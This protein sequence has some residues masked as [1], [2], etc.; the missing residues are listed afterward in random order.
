MLLLATQYVTS[1]MVLALLEPELRG[2][3]AA[4][5]LSLHHGMQCLLRWPLFCHPPPNPVKVS[6]TDR[7]ALA[8]GLSVLGSV[9]CSHDLF[10]TINQY[11][12]H[13]VLNLLPSQW[14]HLR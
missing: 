1:S 10:L 8:H 11:L 12:P 4:D 2:L 6:E 7:P 14:R 3:Y 13:L 5:L 9:G